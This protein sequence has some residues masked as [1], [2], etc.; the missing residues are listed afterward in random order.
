MTG[1]VLRARLVRCL[2]VLVGCLWLSQAIALSAER[3][4]A[5]PD[6]AV[7]SGREFERQRAW[8][9]AI[10]SYETS[11]KQWPENSDLV[12]GL[13]R[14]KF[15]FSIDR[16]Y[17]D[18]SFR[19]GMLKQ[20]QSQALDLLDNVLGN[21]QARFVESIDTKSIIAHGT[22]SLWLALANPK[23]L[24]QNLVAVDAAQIQQL[25]TLLR[26]NYWN[27][28]LSGRNEARHVVGEVCEASQRLAGLPA[29]AVVMEYVFG[30]CNCLDDYSSVLTPARYADMYS[31][32]DG[33]FV[34]IGI[35]IEARLGKGM[36]LV[37]V[38]PDSPA[39]E[40]GLL[41]GEIVVAVDGVDC[42]FLSTEEAAGLLTGAAGS[43][44]QL[45]VTD[46]HGEAHTVTCSRREVHVKSIPVAKMVDAGC[47]V[48][49]LR[50]AAF[51]KRTADELDEALRT[52]Q[53]QGMRS[54]I[55][56]LRG[57]PGGLLDEAVSVADRFID[58]GTI[59]S[60][61]GRLPEDNDVYSAFG[62]GTWKMPLVLLIDGESA[63]ASEIVAGCIKDH[64]RGTIVGRTSYGKW[65]VQT[66]TH[67]TGG[68]GM[69]LTTARF[70][71][72]DG[73]TY[74]KIGLDPDV[75][76]T[77][78]D[79]QPPTR[80]RLSATNLDP[81]TDPDLKAALDILCRQSYTSR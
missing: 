58:D 12:Y 34:G 11:L 49:Y 37:D 28:P 63:S 2:I 50:M 61:R 35:V 29:S 18:E 77:L 44:V 64:H 42:R 60:T 19:T 53:Q 67:L 39:L 24:E 6:E 14:S 78:P 8:R 62:P 13:R 75:P 48:G 70:Y 65:S 31:N 23:F 79:D 73:H 3:T 51:Q 41:A 33:Q 5:T 72:P 59:V 26:N 22:E 17:A 46:D 27:K 9:D 20:S 15:Q 52:L 10:D 21:V 1:Q 30:A 32:I 40:S 47:G 80:R 16:R 25:R 36:E 74:S 56:D 4:V 57:N 45:E 76:V 7:V 38:L 66:I 54:L 43:R 81:Q 71:S 55:W 69:R 68:L